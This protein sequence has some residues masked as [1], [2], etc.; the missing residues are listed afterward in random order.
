M[1]YSHSLVSRQRIYAKIW[2]G[3]E[4]TVSAHSVVGISNWFLLFL[5]FDFFSFSFFFFW[6]TVG[7]HTSSCHWSIKLYYFN[8]FIFSCG[9][10][11]FKKENLL[12][13]IYDSAIFYLMLKFGSRASTYKALLHWLFHYL[14]P[15]IWRLHWMGRWLDQH[16]FIHFSIFWFF[17]NSYYLFNMTV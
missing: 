17:N 7:E 4:H 16:K 11:E 2:E 6:L 5:L 14:L 8:L 15:L 13:H 3:L 12:N 1:F 10:Y 9:N